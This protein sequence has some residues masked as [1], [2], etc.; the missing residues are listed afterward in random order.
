MHYRFR[1]SFCHTPARR[2]ALVEAQLE[3]H[4][5]S[6]AFACTSCGRLLEPATRH[7][8]LWLTVILLPVPVLFGGLLFARSSGGVIASVFFGPAWV[9]FAAWLMPYVTP[10]EPARQTP[11]DESNA[12]DG[13]QP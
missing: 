3:S 5:K 12:T 7:R 6:N 4:Y 1:C 13:G 8:W 11:T 10:L 2:W 9:G